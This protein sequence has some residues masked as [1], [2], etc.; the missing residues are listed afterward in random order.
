MSDA[1]FTILAVTRWAQFLSLFVLFG[2]LSFPFYVTRVAPAPCG[3]ASASAMRRAI[4]VAA[5]VQASSILA[6]AATSI[7]SMG[8]GW[9]SL[10]DAGL[11]KAFFLEASFGRLWLARFLLTALLIGA[12]VAAG[13]RSPGR[14]VISG[15]ALVLVGALLVSQAGIGHPAGLPAGERLFVVTGYALHLLGG[16]A[17]I[18]GLWP[19]RAILAEA[20]HND[21]AHPYV[22]FAL[23][24]FAAKATVAVALVLVGAA[25]NIRPELAAL[26]LSD[27]S[28][29]WWAVIAKAALFG[30]LVAIAY[31]NRFV[32]APMHGVRPRE[33]SQRLLR[34]IMV[35]QGLA[36]AVLAV[37]AFMGVASPTG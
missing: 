7:A 15:A 6:W 26:E 17:W 10:G 32:L 16:A 21:C 37:A 14:N 19:L 12:L 23:Q 27:P 33:T 1:L 13:R 36:V 30:A 29:W 25:I 22:Q 28:S 5:A 35:D 11:V 34:N 18:G 4:A 20:R 2:A 3:E 8:D 31:R 24:R 9:T